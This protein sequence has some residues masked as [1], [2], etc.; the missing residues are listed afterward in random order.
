MLRA[1]GYAIGAPAIAVA[2][3]FLIYAVWDTLILQE[4]VSNASLAWFPAIA[5]LW[6]CL[7]LGAGG[8]LYRQRT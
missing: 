3:G 7:C 6:G 8:L 2:G 5:V 4:I 1:F